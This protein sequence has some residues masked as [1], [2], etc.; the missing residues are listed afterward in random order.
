L[1]LRPRTS[2][3][4]DIDVPINKRRGPIATLPILDEYLISSDSNQSAETYVDSVTEF[5]RLSPRHDPRTQLSGIPAN[6]QGKLSGHNNTYHNDNQVKSNER[7]YI[8]HSKPPMD[9]SRHETIH[10]SHNNSGT[11]RGRTRGTSGKHDKGKNIEAKTNFYTFIVHKNYQNENWKSLNSQNK[12]QGPN[13]ATFD[14]GDHFHIIFSTRNPSNYTRHRARIGSFLHLDNSGNTESIITT[15]RIK[16]LRQF[17]LYC[18]RYGFK[19]VTHHGAKANIYINEF[20]KQLKSVSK[21]N[22]TNDIIS[23]N[24]CKQYIENIKE[25][26]S[27]RL[28]KIKKKNIVET[29]QSLV[30]QYN[31]TSKSDWHRRI[32]IETKSTLLKE[33]GL[34]VDAYLQK[35]LRNKNHTLTGLKSDT[36]WEEIIVEYYEQNVPITI[37]NNNLDFPIINSLIWLNNLFI[38]NNIDIVE[39]FAWSTVIKN[40]KFKKINCLVLQGPTNAGKTL[41]AQQYFKLA[42][43]EEIP[44]ERD[45]SGFHLDQLPYASAALFEEPL[46]TPTNIGSWKLL[47]EGAMVKTDIKNADKEG[48]NRLPIYITCA[49]NICSNVDLSEQEQVKQRIKVFQFHKTIEH[50]EEDFND[51]GSITT[52]CKPPTFITPLI[53]CLL[54][55]YY[56]NDITEFIQELSNTHTI[57]TTELLP[58]AQWH[59]RLHE[60]FHLLH[61]GLA[62][63]NHH[64][65]SLNRLRS[66]QSQEELQQVEAEDQQMDTV[67]EY[68]L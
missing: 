37:Y 68:L 39:F 15:Q 28:G 31:I 3:H 26:S 25:A 24:H 4:L 40:K 6:I 64:L 19:S 53:F 56:Y 58:Q 55:I 42:H 13:F 48:I 10:T 57:D 45:N 21:T 8:N 17:I 9:V 66:D 27:S 51:F 2:K 61:Q 35:I 14:H 36:P 20:I 34:N 38:E 1:Q 29:I 67:S 32:N 52:I 63:K 16:H 46:I 65:K 22:P 43:P 12:K 59:L 44:R 49:K 30:D 11:D 23:S 54:Y 18:L 50:R 41:I 60:N 5:L 7:R 33:F 62:M 47:L